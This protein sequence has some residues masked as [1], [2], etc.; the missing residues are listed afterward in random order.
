MERV[1]EYAGGTIEFCVKEFGIYSMGIDSS[2]GKSHLYHVLQHIDNDLIFTLTY[3]KNEAI[4][5]ERI[6]EFIRSS[7]PVLYI[8][9][10]DMMVDNNVIIEL[11]KS[12]ENRYIILDCK[13]NEFNDLLGVNYLLLLK[14]KDGF[15]LY[16]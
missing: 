5:L 3:D 4:T 8:D 6:K 7:Y 15:K 16:A 10:F 13:D 2:I 1:I 12:I 14:R 9:R 11:L